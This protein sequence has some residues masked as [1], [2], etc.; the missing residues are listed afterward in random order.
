MQ[1]FDHPFITQILKPLP[2]KIKKSSSIDVFRVMN[3]FGRKKLQ[4]TIRRL[5][6]PAASPPTMKYLKETRNQE[7][8]HIF[9]E[10][11]PEFGFLKI[12][13]LL[14]QNPIDRIKYLNVQENMEDVTS[15]KDRFIHFLARKHMW[16]AIIGMARQY[17]I[18]SRNNKVKTVHVSKMDS[19]ILWNA[20]HE[21]AQTKWKLSNIGF[22]EIPRDIIIKGRHIFYKYALIF[23]E[24]MQ[25]DRIDASPHM[26]SGYETF[27][28]YN[29]L[30]HAVIDIAKWLQNRGVRCQPN[31]PL[32]GLVSFV[33]L[34]GKAGL[35]WQGMNGLL[36]TPDYGQRQRIAA[37]Y[38]ET[39]IFSFT[40]STDHSWI[41]KFCPTCRL[42]QQKC[43]PDAIQESKT[44]YNENIPTIGKLSR[45]LDPIK[46]HPQF[47]KWD[48][49]SICVKVCPFSQGRTFY[50][51]IKPKYS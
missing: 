14:Q 49:C 26:E 13:K 51:K 38:V 39:P 36:V 2:D 35:G 28:A 27:R 45:C 15:I 42:C 4:K 11:S 23:I 34:A 6:I 44:V 29:H 25:K 19:Q 20:L 41:E 16:G 22:T 32:G 1:L 21:Y 24:E 47:D 8:L 10:K 12:Q 40:D 48:G 50:D 7:G 46:C 18:I 3:D 43:P 5:S 17:R 31:H 30:G 33:P 9:N 37:I